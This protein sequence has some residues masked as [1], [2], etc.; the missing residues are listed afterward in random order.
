MVVPFL[1]AILKCWA[2]LERLQIYVSF[3]VMKDVHC[4]TISINYDVALLHRSKKKT[5]LK[6]FFVNL[7]EKSRTDRTKKFRFRKKFAEK[8]Q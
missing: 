8:G 6:C 2:S 3:M 1:R 5:N 4:L 7:D